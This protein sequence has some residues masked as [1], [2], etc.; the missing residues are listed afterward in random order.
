MFRC[1]ASAL[2]LSGIV[3]TTAAC[4]SGSISSNRPDA[5][6]PALSGSTAELTRRSKIQHI[7]IV[8]QE[9]RSFD[10]LFCGYPAADGKCAD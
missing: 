8:V 1:N 9:A 7:V 10:N 2:F 3:L 6:G 5:V 4:S